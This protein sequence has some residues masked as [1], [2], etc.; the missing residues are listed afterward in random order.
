MLNKKIYLLSLFICLIASTLYAQ[1]KFTSKTINCGD[2]FKIYSTNGSE[3]IVIKVDKKTLCKVTVSAYCSDSTVQTKTLLSGDL[4][5]I[6]CCD[7]G[8]FI[9]SVVFQCSGL[10]EGE[11]K[12]RYKLVMP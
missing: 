1:D 8:N 12:F 6:T 7:S 3:S 11:C 9:N 5:I 10:A 4:K 2:V